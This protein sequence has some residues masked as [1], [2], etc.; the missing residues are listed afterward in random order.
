M[1]CL[2]RSE[3]GSRER[4]PLSIDTYRLQELPVLM[5]KCPVNL[6]EIALSH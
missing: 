5:Q 1:I 6:E 4:P 3:Y 2:R